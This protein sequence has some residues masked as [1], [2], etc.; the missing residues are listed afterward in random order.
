ML[1]KLP[2]GVRILKKSEGGNK[3]F[4]L[5]KWEIPDK[6]SIIHGKLVSTKGLSTFRII[7]PN[8]R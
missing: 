7:A 6:S 8:L 2:E 4:L 1:R 3:E 5:K